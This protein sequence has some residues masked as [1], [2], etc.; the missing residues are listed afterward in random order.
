VKKIECFI[1]TEKTAEVV[2]ALK[3][4]GATGL[5]VIP[6]QGFGV[7]RVPD[8]V[9]HAKTKLEIIASDES[10]KDLLDAV[11]EQARSGR[12]GDGKI[13]VSTVDEVIRV[14]TGE[15]GAEALY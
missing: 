11:M 3:L 6:V 9:L 7:E 10:L 8:A 4:A 5:T 14:R 12:I 15:R 2:E 13:V 1:R